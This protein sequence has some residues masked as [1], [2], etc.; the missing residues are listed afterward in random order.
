[1]FVVNAGIGGIDVLSVANPTR[2]RKIDD[3]D[4]SDV[5]VDAGATNNVDVHDGVLAVA[6]ANTDEQANGYVAFYDTASRKLLKSV[7][8]GPLPD[9]VTFTPDG[10]TVLAA[11]EGEPN[12]SYTDDPE[13]SVSVIDVSD[14]V[15]NATLVANAGFGDV[16]VPDGVRI[17]GPGSTA[18]QDLEPEYVAVSEDSSTAYVTLQENNALGVVDVASASVER[19]VALGYKDHSEDGNELD[20][21]DD[22]TVDIRSEPLT[23]MYQPDS[24]PSI[25]ID[26]GT[27]LV[28]ANEGDAR[29]YDALFELGFL[30]ET[31][32]GEYVFAVDEDLS[33]TVDVDES[34]FTADELDRLDAL[35][36][37]EGDDGLEA[38]VARGDVD[39]DGAVEEIHVFGDRSFA[40]WEADGAD[41]DLVY[42]SGDELERIT[43]DALPEDFNSDDDSVNDLDGESAASGPEPEGTAAGYVGD[44]PVAFVGLE[45]I[46]GI[47]M[48][49]LSD[50]TSPELVEYVNGRIF[51]PTELGLD[52]DADLGDAI[53]N[54]DIE[55]GD[56]G[57]LGPEGLLFVPAED[58]P[59]KVPLLIV[60]NEVS[61]TTTIYEVGV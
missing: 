8:V 50:P 45:E 52:A 33:N 19:V 23:G 21:V 13:G 27:Y 24:I 59:K 16:T 28:T 42:E 7:E 58:A 29:E 40:V 6:I 37:T 10:N 31:S 20:A 9:M 17:Y 36:G 5:A 54:G 44:T 41:V 18:A 35:S 38:T 25:E 32:E 60:G 51:D 15:E 55:P 48:F 3:I 46:G 57:D 12:S 34:A 1:M 14:G 61:G 4:G 2:P 53:E 22:G 43:A 56:A 11:N 49:D 30:T 26:G 39:D 47:A